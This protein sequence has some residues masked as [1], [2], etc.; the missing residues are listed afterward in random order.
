MVLKPTFCCILELAC[1]VIHIR[2]TFLHL[3]VGKLRITF[4]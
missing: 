2:N 3:L 1:N 4:L